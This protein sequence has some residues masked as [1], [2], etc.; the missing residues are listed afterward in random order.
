MTKD[1][2]LFNARLGYGRS[3]SS[4]FHRL[5]GESIFEAMGLGTK[6]VVDS[7]IARE[8]HSGEDIELNEDSIQVH[9][10][11]SVENG[12]GPKFN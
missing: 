3:R 1:D 9:Q 11:I 4:S 10:E 8:L 7:G 6:F 12:P 2:R 5:Q